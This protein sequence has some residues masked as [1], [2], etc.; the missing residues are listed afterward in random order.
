MDTLRTSLAAALRQ[1]PPTAAEP[2]ALLAWG[3]VAGPHLA[4]HAAAEELDGGILRLHVPEAAWRREIEAFRPELL[5]QLAA[6][7]G[8][9]RVVGLSFAPPRATQPSVAAA[10]GNSEQKPRLCK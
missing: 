7:L 6:V 9:D 3:L 5:R 2:A 10:A 1:M 4:A 8:P